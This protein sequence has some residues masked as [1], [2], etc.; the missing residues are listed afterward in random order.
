MD[1]LGLALC[2]ILID[3]FAYVRKVNNAGLVKIRNNINALK[4]VLYLLGSTTA[5]ADLDRAYEY[6]HLAS[7]GAK[8]RSPPF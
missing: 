6:Y 1:E 3:D 7:Y 4:Q 2:R 8:V 5:D